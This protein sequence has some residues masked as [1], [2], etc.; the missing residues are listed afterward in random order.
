MHAILTQ[1]EAAVC[2]AHFT[3][4]WAPSQ[5]RSA[6]STGKTRSS[7]H[8]LPNGDLKK[9]FGVHR[10]GSVVLALRHACQTVLVNR[11]RMRRAR[12][13]AVVRDSKRSNPLRIE[14]SVHLAGTPAASET[15]WNKSHKQ[16]HNPCRCLRS[17]RVLV[18]IVQEFV[19]AVRHVHFLKAAERPLNETGTA[20]G[21]ASLQ[22]PVQVL[23]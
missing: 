3:S 10:S 6:R 13:P 11:R 17:L 20:S 23:A 15:P 19:Q 18:A 9:L 4:N 5:R 1:S 14:S 8:L 7:K 22:I 21:N 12:A 16:F 2:M